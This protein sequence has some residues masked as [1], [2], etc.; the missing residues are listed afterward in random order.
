[1]PNILIEMEKRHRRRDVGDAS[2]FLTNLGYEGYFV[3]NGEL[4]TLS[5][6]NQSI[7]HNPATLAAGRRPT[8]GNACM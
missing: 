7:H 6:F 1:M 3:L 2:G 4:S 5:R 8:N